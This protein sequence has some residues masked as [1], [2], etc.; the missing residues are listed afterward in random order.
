MVSSYI[1]QQSSFWPRRFLVLK[2]YA[3]F[4]LRSPIVYE[5]AVEEIQKRY[6]EITT[7]FNAEIDAVRAETHY[8]WVQQVLAETD[9][10]SSETEKE[11]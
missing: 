6:E 8:K 5:K 3:F 11:L 2:Q 10:Q 9:E 4:L 1:V 7:E